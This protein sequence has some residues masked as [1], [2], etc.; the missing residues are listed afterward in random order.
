MAA[1]LGP[2]ARGETQGAADPCCKPR[3]AFYGLNRGIALGSAMPPSRTIEDQISTS[4][5]FPALLQPR[6]RPCDA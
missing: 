1:N 3:A 5:T 4:D 2:D 6:V